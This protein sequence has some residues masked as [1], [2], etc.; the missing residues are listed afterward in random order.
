M[1]NTRQAL[2]VI[3][4]GTSFGRIYLEG[5]RR[6]PQVYKLVGILARGSENSMTQAVKYQV[7]L[8]TDFD[9]LPFDQ[10]DVACVV[11]R[12]TVVNGPG[13][14][15]VEKFLEK[16][17]HVVQEQ[18]VHHDDVVQCLRTAKKY[19]VCFVVNSFY[20]DV[21]PIYRFIHAAKQVLKKTEPVYFDVACSVH[22]LFPLIDIVGQCLGGLTPWT[23]KSGPE[24][25]E[26]GPLTHL[27]GHI[28]NIPIGFRIQNQI[29]PK[30]PDN[31]TLLLHRLELCTKKG[32][33]LLTD[34]HGYVLWTP[35]LH[36]MRREDGVLDTEGFD[37][38]HKLYTT[39]P[40]GSAATM[41]MK[42]I[43]TTLWP[44]SI[45]QFMFRFSKAITGQVLPRHSGQYY[46][47]VCR[48]WQDIGNKIGIPKV[49]SS[50]NLEPLPLSDF[51]VS[52]QERSNYE[53]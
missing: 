9:K 23:L 22:V 50:H 40:A 48:L 39:E 11:V 20:P 18:P 21:G 15:I 41:P 43:F 26:T 42:E 51:N 8:Y 35:H 37:P 44:E 52:F 3:V 1:K 10:I 5:I 31:D 19:G 47:S 2:K 29:N 13:S 49:I 45:Q 14:R 30:D 24:F 7:P 28:K 32:T 33:L 36:V 17:I 4:C 46:L 25:Q 12:S 34:T 16:G 53:S 27:S 6:L 38:D